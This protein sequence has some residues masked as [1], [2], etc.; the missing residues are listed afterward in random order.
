MLNDVLIDNWLLQDLGIL[1]QEGLSDRNVAQLQLSKDGFSCKGKPEFLLQIDTLFSFL[2]DIVTRD[3]LVVD[4]EWAS[5]WQG[6]LNMVDQ[7]SQNGIIQLKKIDIQD[8]QSYE[9][10]RK[11]AIES[12]GYCEMIKTQQERNKQA[13][14]E[15]GGSDDRFFGQ[16]FGGTAGNLGRSNYL[17][18]PYNPHPLRAD[19]LHQLNHKIWIPNAMECTRQQIQQNRTSLFAGDVGEQFKLRNPQLLLDPVIV[20]I[21]EASKDASDLI[22]VACQLRDSYQPFRELMKGYQKALILENAVE[23]KAFK[24]HFDE[25]DD[26]LLRNKS[27]NRFGSLKVSLPLWVFGYSKN[28]GFEKLMFKFGARAIFK[29]MLFQ[30]AGTLSLKKLIRI[31]GGNESMTKLAMEYYASSE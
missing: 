1:H 12:M 27:S 24:N 15:Q 14:K 31:L 3:T 5:A 10:T 13:W 8:N 7:L 29:K 25:I 6:R 18:I 17:H 11:A 26:W 28:L 2:V 23:L 30:P 19:L 16:M 4:Q 21:I 20:E 22:R 9:Q